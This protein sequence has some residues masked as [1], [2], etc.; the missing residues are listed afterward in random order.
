MPFHFE[1]GG[2]GGFLGEREEEDFETDAVLGLPTRMPAISPRLKPAVITAVTPVSISRRDINTVRRPR[3]MITE[4]IP[5]ELAGPQPFVHKRIIGAVTGGVRS[6]ITGGNP[7]VGGARGFIEGGR[8]PTMPTILGP[9]SLSGEFGGS[10]CPP[11]RIRVGN[12]C[13]APTAALPGGRPF[14]VPAGGGGTAADG[15]VGMLSG[16]PEPAMEVGTITR[17]DGSVGPI[18][19]CPP[20]MVLAID[21][22]CYAKGLKGLATF[23]KWKPGTKPFLTGGEVK[24]LRKAD[25]LRNS[26]SNRK[27]LKGLGMG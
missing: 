3:P 18:L 14:T 8:R 15:L 12:S 10:A 22:N 5:P 13:V 21:N 4:T 27:L 7:L 24:C 1:E 25:S 16:G 23:R 6:L 11:G 17:N 2:E 9:G 20:G 19:R 26:K